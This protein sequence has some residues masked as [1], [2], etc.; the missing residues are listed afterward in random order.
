MKNSLPEGYRVEKSDEP[1][2]LGCAYKVFGPRCTEYGLIRNQV[3]PQNMFVINLKTVNP[4]AKLR[5]YGWWT[6]KNGDLK[7]LR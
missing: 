7:P 4:N 3:N 1:G 6:D 5:G 2:I